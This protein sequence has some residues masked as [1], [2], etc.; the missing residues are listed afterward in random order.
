MT[1]E[2]PPDLLDKLSTV[3]DA[4][5]A[6]AA[7]PSPPFRT[8]IEHVLS[9]CEVIIEGRRTIMVGSNNYLG[10]S[11]NPE[12]CALGAEAASTYGVGT[13]GSRLA[14]GTFALHEALE[15]EL[16]AFMGRRHAL[17]FTTGHQ[18]NLAVIGALA[19]RDDVVF[20]D[21]DC[22]ASI[23]DACTLSGAQTVRF[24]HNSPEDLDRRLG[25]LDPQAR[26]KLVV[27]EGCYSVAG[28]VAPLPELVEIKDRHNAYLAVDEAHSFGVFGARGRGVAEHFGVEER[29][30]FVIATFSKALASTGG[31]CASDLDALPL[32]RYCA[33]AYMFT[34]SGTPSSV[35]TA[36]GALRMIAERPGLRERLWA[37]AR[38]MREGLLRL[39]FEVAST[40]SPIVTLIIG[41][42]A[43]AML[44]WESLLRAGLYCNLFVPPATPRDGCLLRTSYTSEH[45]QA[46]LDEALAIFE[47]VGRNHGVI[48]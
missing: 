30:D 33:R 29:V 20:V 22:H 5:A 6:V 4:V 3:R 10:L 18:A 15:R 23:Y 9:P 19:G 25:R 17:I 40:G 8:V 12:L 45:T 7:L 11:L 35:A 16:A 26:N 28:D 31:F 2:R 24:R 37:N 46:V 14:N 39:G 41:E 27:V 43:L 36:R 34:A 44:L 21:A 32:L 48:S 47:R 38:F 42:E 1:T 13:T